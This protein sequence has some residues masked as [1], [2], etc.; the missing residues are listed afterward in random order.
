MFKF[1]SRL[2]QWAAPLRTFGEI[3]VQPHSNLILFHM[4]GVE[5]TM[6]NKW[7]LTARFL[8]QL[9]IPVHIPLTELRWFYIQEKLNSFQ[10][11]ISMFV[12]SNLMP[13]TFEILLSVCSLHNIIAGDLWAKRGEHGI[14]REVQNECDAR[15]E[16]RRKIMRLL[17]VHCSDSPTLTAWK[18]R[19]G[20]FNCWTRYF[21]MF[22]WHA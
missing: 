17:P 5:T 16:G 18:L 12:A 21:G 10:K 2:K 8:S 15:N 4:N 19:S 7:S 11:F 22:V 1:F 20:W 3:S 9:N 13:R 6:H 14:L